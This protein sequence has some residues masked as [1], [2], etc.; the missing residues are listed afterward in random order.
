MSQSNDADVAEFLG[1]VAPEVRALCFELR[2][3]VRHIAPAAEE[4]IRF[5]AL[6]IFEPNRAFGAIGGNIC[7]L[8]C[9]GDHVRLE[10]I[11]GAALPDPDGLLR[12]NG[13]AKRYIELRNL[14]EVRRESIRRLIA[15]AAARAA[16]SE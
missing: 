16:N 6:C 2:S 8:N 11:H 4:A 15:A 3:I 5:H 7:M 1:S 10:F 9:R 12:G 14:V 13:K